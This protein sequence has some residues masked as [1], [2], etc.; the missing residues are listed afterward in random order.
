MVSFFLR[1]LL[2]I[3]ESIFGNYCIPH[4]SSILLGFKFWSSKTLRK[5]RWNFFQMGFHGHNFESFLDFFF[6]FPE[7]I[8]YFTHSW[9]SFHCFSIVRSSNDLPNY[10][11]A[12]DQDLHRLNDHIKQSSTSWL[13]STIFHYLIWCC[14]VSYHFGSIEISSDFH[15]TEFPS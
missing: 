15:A 8:V 5:W 9:C 3:C 13:S 10:S 7:Y 1:D 2:G 14:L 11:D 12:N 4:L 6:W